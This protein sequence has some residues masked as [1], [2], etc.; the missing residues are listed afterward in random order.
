MAYDVTTVLDA[1]E[2]SVKVAG[3]LV[4]T[5][6]FIQAVGIDQAGTK[7][8]SGNPLH[9]QGTVLNDIKALLGGSV[10]AQVWKSWEVTTTQTGVN[11]WTPASGKK[12][13]ID[14]I[15][16]WVGGTTAGTIT[17]WLG[18]TGDTAYSAGTDQPVIGPWPVIPS[19]TVAPFFSPPLRESLI[20]ATADHCLKIT[21]SAGITVNG[22]AYGYEA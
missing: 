8:G 18:A 1:S 13:A 6:K 19:A 16:L 2:Q 5:D 21:T 17:I 22:V 15:A 11:I 20:A 14:Y 12:V 4:E 3:T 10:A 7:V 9:V